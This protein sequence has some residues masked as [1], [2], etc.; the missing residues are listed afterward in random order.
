MIP[1]FSVAV[2]QKVKEVNV[3]YLLFLINLITFG[4]N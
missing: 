4:I 2:G 1:M 3:F